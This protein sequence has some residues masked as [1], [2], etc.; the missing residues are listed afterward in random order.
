MIN[1]T[2]GLLIPLDNNMKPFSIIILLSGIMYSACTFA[3]TSNKLAVGL[4]INQFQKD[5]GIG[6]HVISPFFIQNSI[7]IRLG[8]NVQWLQHVD[9]KQTTTWT[10]FPAFQLG[11]RG[12]H[13]ILNE[14]LHVYGEGGSMLLLPNSKFST[15]QFVIGGY[16][17]FGFEFKP[18]SK[19][20]YFIELG[21]VGTGAIA[22]KV[23]AKPI[24]SNGFMT[25]TG[26][27]LYL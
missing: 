26:F 27:R 1:K 17:L 5:F 22:D 10:A 18:K 4:N 2:V 3:Q 25:S 24:Y 21:G 19:L 12:K 13:P 7:A 14:Q 6:L 9:D 8:G 23:T 11:V 15:N 16:G 20:A